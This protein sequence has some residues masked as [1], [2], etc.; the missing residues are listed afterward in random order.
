MFKYIIKDMME[1]VRYLPYGILAGIF[2][3]VL[4]CAVNGVKRARRKTSL[5]VL[6]L[7][8]LF[9]Y[10]VILLSLTFLSRE[11]GSRKGIDW[12]LF[13]TWG[14]NRRNN[15]YVIENI[16]L[17]IPYGCVCAW[18]VPCVRKLPVSFLFGLL[19]SAGI[20][21]LQ[22][23]TRRGFFQ[24]DDILTNVIGNAVGYALFRWFCHVGRKRK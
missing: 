23:V 4:L 13:S 2:M 6:A 14:I 9:M 1:T 17:F 10:L 24:I 8:C 18:A 22:L 3:A 15:A 11:P 12:E 5:S 19:T 7:V 21:C 20:E 16:F